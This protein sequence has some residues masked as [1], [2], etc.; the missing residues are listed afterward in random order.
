MDMK[1]ASV[2]YRGNL[3]AFLFTCNKN[4]NS[5]EILLLLWKYDF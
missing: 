2:N 3:F 1:I 4:G 5:Q